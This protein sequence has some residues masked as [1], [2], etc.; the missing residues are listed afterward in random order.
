[1]NKNLFPWL[2]NEKTSKRSVFFVKLDHINLYNL[3]KCRVNQGGSRLV[4]VCNFFPSNLDFVF[5]PIFPLVLSK[6]LSNWIRLLIPCTGTFHIILER[7][8]RSGCLFVYL[9]RSHSQQYVSLCLSGFAIYATLPWY[10]FQSTLTS[11][12]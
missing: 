5:F 12:S 1:M 7:V 6:S 4:L 9:M 3:S 11:S 2:M 8:G 10:F